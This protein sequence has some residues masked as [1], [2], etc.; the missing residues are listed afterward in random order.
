MAS[1]SEDFGI[2]KWLNTIKALPTMPDPYW[3]LK[4][5]LLSPLHCESLTLSYILVSPLHLAQG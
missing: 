5:K 2:F 3:V 1:F 4:K